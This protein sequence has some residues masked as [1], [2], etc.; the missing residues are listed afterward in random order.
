MNPIPTDAPIPGQALTDS[1]GNARWE[2]PPQYVDLDEA[3]EFLWK[4]L[5]SRNSQ[6]M[7]L[8]ML[9]KGIPVEML[10]D[11][12]I[13]SGFSEGKWTPD[14]GMMLKLPVMHMLAAIGVREGV[15]G[16]TPIFYKDRSVTE[17][18]INLEKIDFS[19]MHKKLSPQENMNIKR[20]NTPPAP[21]SGA[22]FM[23]PMGG[24]NGLSA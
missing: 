1:P 6:I 10:A 16:D 14:V 23:S 18:L 12:V 5:Q 15:G 9:D 21:I 8:A 20:E 3:A 7:L 19:N 11:V 17:S 22:G 2:S 4:Q 24:M 13:F